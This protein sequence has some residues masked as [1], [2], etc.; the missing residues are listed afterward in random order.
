MKCARCGREA[1]ESRTTEATELENGGLLVIRHIPCYQCDVCGEIMYSG[2]V[3]ERM[4]N[5]TVQAEAFAQEMTVVNY[6]RAS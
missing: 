4:E 1:S 2:D 6:A 5:L 3:V